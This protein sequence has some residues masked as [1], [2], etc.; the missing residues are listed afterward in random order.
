VAHPRH[1]ILDV[2][3]IIVN[4]KRDELPSGHVLL[5]RH[6]LIDQTRHGKCVERRCDNHAVPLLRKL[7]DFFRHL[8][9]A[10][11]DDATRV[12]PDRL[13]LRLLAVA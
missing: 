10:A 5:D 3:H 6:T 1:D 13:H 12:R 9:T 4:V 2:V 11:D 7:F 8:E